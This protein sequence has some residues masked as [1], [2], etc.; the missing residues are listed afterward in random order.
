MNMNLPSFFSTLDDSLNAFSCAKVCSNVLRLIMLSN[1]L[2]GRE[3]GL[4]TSAKMCGFE[5]SS[6]FIEIMLNFP[7]SR[8]RYDAFLPPPRSSTF[9][10]SLMCEMW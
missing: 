7:L 3:N 2:S 1:V 8:R 5:R 6:I 9:P 10:F 4:V